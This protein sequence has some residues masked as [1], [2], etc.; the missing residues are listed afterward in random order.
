MSD[1]PP[2]R[3]SGSLYR[4]FHLGLRDRVVI[5]FG[6]LALAMST[7][8]AAAVWVFVSGYLVDQ[9]ESTSI[10][11]S[12]VNAEVIEM[13]LGR[14]DTEI[15]TLLDQIPSRDARFTLISHQGEW[16]ATYPNQGPEAL[17]PDLVEMVQDGEP[18]TQRTEVDGDLV[19]AV[20]IP[21]GT[22]DAYFALFPLE[23]LNH[24]LQ[25][26]AVT[27]VAAAVVTAFAGMALGR[28]ASGVALRPLA[29][30]ND[31]AAAV[32]G[33]DMGARLHHEKD[34]DLG[35]LARSFNRTA[36]A[37]QRRVVVDARFASDVSHELRTPLTTMLNSMQLIQNRQAELPESAREPVEMLAVDLERFRRLVVDLLE[38]SRDEDEIAD[39][40]TTE[41]VLIGELVR[42]AADAAAGRMV[43]WVTADVERLWLGVDKRRLKRV[44]A[45]LVENAENH[46]GRC[47]GVAV[48]ATEEMVRV[49]VDDAGPGIPP[50]RRDEIFGRFAGGGAG[51]RGVGLGLA[52]VARHVQWHGGAIDV[53]DRPGGG[54]RFVVTLPRERRDRGI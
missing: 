2:S 28:V 30:L 44:V 31:V 40:S 47:A 22:A 5:G 9:R 15:P 19:L 51:D 25:S 42:Q 4:R 21:I 14:R 3:H 52:I 23:G 11:Q 8:L 54:A 10:V 53:L 26:L 13:G 29:E 35:G 38:I 39:R 27:L 48:L 33:G 34:P 37:L 43:T 32:A 41:P 46:G 17:P 6:L 24:T 45:N 50:D 1:Q 12:T 20:G 36:D 18:A 16:Y 7:I 49:E